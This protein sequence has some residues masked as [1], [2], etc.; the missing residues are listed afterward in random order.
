MMH[1]LAKG[2]QAK[3]GQTLINLL[4]L[5]RFLF[6]IL[7]FNHITALFAWGPYRHSEQVLHLL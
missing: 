5:N 3:R 2:T 1:K 6:E 4:N 7:L